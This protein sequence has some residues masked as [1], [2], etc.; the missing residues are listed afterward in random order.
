MALHELLG[1]GSGKDLTETSSGVFNFDR[2]SLPLN[3]LT[4][5]PI[6]SWYAPGQSWKPLFGTSYEE[7]RCESVALYLALFDE[8]MS[9]FGLEE[10]GMEVEDGE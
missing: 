8:V 3:P 6:E 2:D 5:A 7:C 9:S 1:H 4:G 10:Q